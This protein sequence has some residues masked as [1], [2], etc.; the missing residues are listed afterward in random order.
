MRTVWYLD[1]YGVKHY[2]VIQTQWEYN[3]LKE[4]YS[5]VNELT[6]GEEVK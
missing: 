4:R 5:F 3:I 6:K 1:D 2:T